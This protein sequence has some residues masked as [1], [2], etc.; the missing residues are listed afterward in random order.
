L[1]IDRTFLEVLTIEGQVLW[2]VSEIGGNKI[3]LE[4][5][6]TRVFLDFGMSFSDRAKFYH[7][8]Y[9]SPKDERGLLEFGILPD[10]K[11][12][13]CFDES[14]AAIDAVILSHSHSD[15]ASCIPFLKRMIP[16]YC[17]QT[18]ASLLRSLS[19]VRIKSFEPNIRELKINTFRTGDKIRIGSLE[20]E[21][22]H[23]D[24]SV[25]AAYGFIIHTSEGTVVYTGDLRVHGTKAQMTLDFAK[26]VEEAKPAVMICDGTN[27]TGADVSSEDEVKAKI[28]KVVSGTD[29]LVLADFSYA[30]ID[31]F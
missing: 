14:E 23:V 29:K 7:E 15:H 8:P 6:D 28:A 3:L 10:L 27:I 18:T 1:N 9:L 26:R 19:E 17:G 22:I 13:Y 2:G 5:C 11:S 25:P 12:I 30:D 20:I 24:H 31:R 4:D 21:P 16:V